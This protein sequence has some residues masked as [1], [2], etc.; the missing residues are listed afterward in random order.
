[1]HSHSDALFLCLKKQFFDKFVI[2][3]W[4]SENFGRLS[5]PPTNRFDAQ[6]FISFFEFSTA[7]VRLLP[8]PP[9][10]GVVVVMVVAAVASTG[11]SDLSEWTRFRCEKQFPELA[12]KDKEN[13]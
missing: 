13:H 11:T 10:L 3:F 9:P 1:M 5:M 7:L 8:P 4:R 6:A 12:T 2:K